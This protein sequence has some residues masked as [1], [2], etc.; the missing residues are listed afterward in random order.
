M[1]LTKTLRGLLAIFVVAAI[2]PL[3]VFSVARS[4]LNTD[5]E[6]AIARQ[7]IELTATAAVQ[8]QER[9][10][11]SA[12]QLLVSVS[13]VPGLVEG[14]GNA[15]EGYLKSLNQ[16]LQAYTSI[17]IV[18]SQGRVLCHSAAGNVGDDLGGGGY[19]QAA[20]TRDRFTASGHLPGRTDTKPL[21]TF[22]LPVKNARGQTVAAAVAALYFQEL[23][24]AVSDVKLPVAS[25]LTIMDRA[26]IVLVESTGNPAAIGQQVSSPLLKKA[27]QSGTVGMLEGEDLSGVQKIYAL[28][29]TKAASD[30]AFFIAVGLDRDAAVEP[31]RRQLTL[32]L[33]ALMLVT[34]LGCL[35]AWFVGGRTIMRPALAVLAA[36][37]KVQAGHLD[38]RIPIAHGAPHHELTQIADGF[39]L[40][41]AAIERREQE[42]MLELQR[43]EQAWETLDTTVNSLKDGLIAV[44]SDARIL[45]ANGAARKIFPID[46]D[47][48]P[49]SASW[50]QM[51]GL[52][53]PGTQDLYLL[54]D[55]PLHKALNG[56]TGGPQHIFV[57]NSLVPLGQLISASYRPVT[58]S[59]GR[60]GALMEF[61]DITELDKL[62]QEQKRHYLALEKSRLQLLDAQRLGRIGH[63]QID[64]ASK[65]ISWSDQLYSLFELAPGAF[66]GQLETFMKM[67]HPADR[68]KFIDQHAR[69][70]QAN[71][72]LDIEYRIVTPC[73]QTRW[74]H[75]VGQ[76]HVDQDGHFEYRAGVLQEITERKQAELALAHT[77]ELLNRTGELAMVGGWEFVLDDMR[78]EYSEQAYRIHDLEPGVPISA[79]DAKKAY[80]PEALQLF[81]AAVD[82]A[83]KNGT[84]WDLELPLT[85]RRGR[86]IWVRTQGQAV[87]VGGKT[88]KLVGALQDIT[89]QRKSRDQLRLLQTCVSRLN[90]IVLITEAEPQGKPGRRIVFVNDAFERLTGYNREE[91]LGQSPRFLHGPNTQKAELK[92]IG[93]AFRNWQPVR[94]ELINYTKSGEEF[95]VELDIVPVSNDFGWYTH[96]VS[97][98]RDITKRK[99]A[100]RELRDSEQRYAA[101]FEQAP[102]PMWVYDTETLQ[103]LTVN[104]AAAR[105]YGYSNAEFLSMSILDIRRDTDALQFKKYLNQKSP[106]LSQRWE[107]RRKDGSVFPV[108][109][110]ARPIQFAG[111]NARFALAL[112]VSAQVQAENEVSDY[113]TTLERAALASQTITLHLSV[114]KLMDEVASQAR[115]VIGSHQAVISLFADE[116]WANA[117]HVFS[118][119]DKYSAFGVQGTA[120]EP[121]PQKS[122]AIGSAD[123]YVSICEKN[124]VMRLTQAELALHP[125]WHSPAGF[126]AQ[127][128]AMRGWLAVALT[129][130]NGKKIGL[131]QLSDKFQGDFTLQDEYVAT[132]LA[133]LASIAIENAQ[134]LEEVHQLNTGLEQ[135]VASRT[136][137]LARQEALFRAVAEQAP[138]VIWTVDPEGNVTYLNR[139]WF[140]LMGGQLS[141]WNG[142]KWFAAIHP[143]DL[144]QVRANWLQ[145]VASQSPFFG[146]RRLLAKDG[147]VHAMS[148]RASP[149][150]DT[151]GKVDYWVGIDADITEIKAVESALRLSNE[152]LE[153]FSYSVSHDLRSPLNTVDGFSR[154]LGKQ[155]GTA[156]KDKEQHYLARIQAGVAQMGKLIEDL[157][158]LAQVS[159]MQLQN[160]AVDLTLICQRIAED[161]KSRDLARE[162]DVFI[163]NGLHAYGDSGLIQIVL[164][165]LL[166][167]AWKF[168]SQLA[169]A[170]IRV[171]QKTDALGL[172]VF[173]VSDNGAGFDM[174]YADKLF[175]AFQRLHLA[176]EFPG[177]GIGLATVNRA[178]ARHGGLL[179]A[180]AAVGKGATFYFT[181]PMP[182][183]ST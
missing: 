110:V 37:Q 90:D 4:V 76:T 9:V 3:F 27:I 143:D 171:G 116:D 158:S 92:R 141:D 80:P 174:A 98:E 25:E 24:K 154:L 104:N 152:E 86:S 111:K 109:G 164:E 100:E 179:W 118:L 2:A 15:C 62:Q 138:Q 28:A 93:E 169:H 140:D 34:A 119:S 172:P 87:Q 160:K 82:S 131:L 8:T 135:K 117:L 19:F 108:R 127:Q 55:L 1:M 88:V 124:Q 54:E 44:A 148:Y 30:S 84:S 175:V 77:A 66:D 132:E 70:L 11:D 107:H 13:R 139:A 134:L 178:I 105:E 64:P 5:R 129:G 125:G 113:L 17:G 166:G 136:A 102:V 168:T 10:T 106:D 114:N 50:P 83:I 115:Y 151:A 122:L 183:S 36:T 68:A 89:A 41:A 79:D 74:M 126:A 7:N 22:A 47:I 43:S 40:M 69:A 59:E 147:S 133:Q 94:S 95:W 155:L 56:Q 103:F 173:F 38:A 60:A 165:N 157:L 144:R 48:T 149:V 71:K 146:M 14:T 63:W 51:L 142:K 170:T 67:I 120:G 161:L 12:H 150:F 35:L 46:P 61:S 78:L 145:S 45:L 72:E 49:L 75:Q 53:V 42:L 181:L 16:D 26:G 137:A 21:I 33:I 31:A 18:S 112:D 123:V 73:G 57:K 130:R 65:L 101:L 20:L 58:D 159:R 156:V 153:A 6:L 99:Q 167:N 96:W 81:E 32:E 91:V 39:N 182:A 29:Q 52:Y 128:P 176:S 23:A 177:T 85:T 162:V 180:Q 121:Q 163:E 97:V